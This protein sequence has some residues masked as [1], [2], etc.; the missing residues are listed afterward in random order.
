MN[1]PGRKYKVTANSIKAAADELG[2]TT[3]TIWRWSVLT[4]T[5]KTTK[6]GREIQR[7][8]VEINES[9]STKGRVILRRIYDK[10]GR[11]IWHAKRPKKRTKAELKRIDK[12]YKEILLELAKSD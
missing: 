8:R 6:E 11:V 10:K 4:Y 1:Q 2:I 12:L 5:T 7:P 3:R 9:R